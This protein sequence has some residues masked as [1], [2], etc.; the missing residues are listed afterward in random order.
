MKLMLESVFENFT[1]IIFKNP[2]AVH[3]INT[4]K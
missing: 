1:P 2:L 4:K 3:I